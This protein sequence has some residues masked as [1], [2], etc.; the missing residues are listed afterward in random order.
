MSDIEEGRKQLDLLS[1]KMKDWY[2][3]DGTMKIRVVTWA[4][5]IDEIIIKYLIRQKAVR[6][7][8]NKLMSLT[9]ELAEEIRAFALQEAHK[10]MSYLEIATAMGGRFHPARVS[11]ALNYKDKDPQWMERMRKRIE[12]MKK[13]EEEGGEER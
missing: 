4:S 7:A 6:R 13:K 9:P 10:N 12:R 11:E 3:E 8:I 2:W 1:K 5:E